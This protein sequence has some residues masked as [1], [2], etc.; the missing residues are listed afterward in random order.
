[1]I[2]IRPASDVP[3]PDLER[4]FETP[5]DPRTCWCQ[6]FKIAGAAWEAA[7]ARDLAP[8]LHEQTRGG[9]PTPGLTIRPGGS[10]SSRA[11]T[12]RA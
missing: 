10:P 6:Y 2:V 4:I 9:D 1:M 8:M 11:K 7:D 5:G 12:T 3:W